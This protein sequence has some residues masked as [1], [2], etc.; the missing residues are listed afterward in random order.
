MP[1]QA[2]CDPIPPRVVAGCAISSTARPLDVSLPDRG[3]P[4]QRRSD[5]RRAAKGRGRRG[6][7]VPA[8]RV[9]RPVALGAGDGPGAV[10]GGPGRVQRRAMPGGRSGSCGRPRRCRD[11][12]GVRPQ[13]HRHVPVTGRCQE[14]GTRTRAR[15]GPPVVENR[16]QRTG[17]APRGHGRQTGPAVADQRGH[18]WAAIVPRWGASPA[19]GHRS[20][21]V[22]TEVSGGDKLR[23]TGG[24]V[25]PVCRVMKRLF[26]RAGDRVDAAMPPWGRFGP[27]VSVWRNWVDR[28]CPWPARPGYV[29]SGSPKRRSA[30]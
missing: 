29:W 2:G 28:P 24:P 19:A 18:G 30:D 22:G 6:P 17:G 15:R 20:R 4:R 8:S 9:H 27:V 3:A 16:M 14:A 11:A 1:C 13:S 25:T 7:D 23:R 12:G 21:A 10:R 5:Q 26:P